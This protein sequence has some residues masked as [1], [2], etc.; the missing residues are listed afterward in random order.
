[1]FAGLGIAALLFAAAAVL[2]LPTSLRL[3]A[4]LAGHE[5]QVGAARLD[6]RSGRMQ[7]AGVRLG[8]EGAALRAQAAGVDLQLGD[9][10]VGRDAVESV[11][12]GDLELE[13]TGP[14]GSLGSPSAEPSAPGFDARRLP[15]TIE[16]ERL[17]WR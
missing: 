12:I 10:L 4:R 6:W 16:L 15:R 13:L 1:M 7:L 5:L 14:I 17:R 3:A 8:A 9:V 11:R 2:W